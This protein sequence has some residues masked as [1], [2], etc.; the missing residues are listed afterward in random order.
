VEDPYAFD[1]L[2]Q[3]FYE[4]PIVP[5]PTIER[6]ET[7]QKSYE[8]DDM[9]VFKQLRLK[10]MNYWRG[11]SVKN[12][13]KIREAEIKALKKEA[14]E[15]GIELEETPVSQK[16]VTGEGP[17]EATLELTGGVKEHVSK[18]DIT[19]DAD[20][21]DYLPESDDIEARG[22]PI[23]VLVPQATTMKADKMVY[24]RAANIVKLYG[25][26]EVIKDGST[27]YGDFMQVNLNEETSYADNVKTN[28]DAVTLTSRTAVSDESR[29]I[30]EDGKITAEQ[31][32]ILKFKSSMIRG[33][34]NDAWIIDDDDR[35]FIRDDVGHDA[36][37]IKTNG[38]TVDARKKHTVISAKEAE[39]LFGDKKLFTLPAFKAFTNKAGNY[40]EANYPELGSIGMLG[41]YAGPGIVFG[42]P[43]GAVIKAMPILNYRNKIGVGGALK[44]KSATNTTD[45]AYGTAADVFIVR[46]KQKFDDNF[47]LQYGINSYMDDWFLGYRRPKYMVEA[48][49]DNSTVI[50]DTLA[51]GLNLRFRHRISGGFMKD[52][53]VNRH[54]EDIITSNKSTSRFRYMAE[55]AQSVYKYENRE[56]RELLDLSLVMQGSAAI[57]GTGDTQFI[58]RVG[59]NIHSQYKN[60]MQDIGYF[61]SAYQ[62]NTPMP[63]FDSYRYGHSAI[64][65][66]EAFRVNK[67]ITLAWISTINLS[68]D[69]P[70]R[71]M[72]QEN[73]FFVS[74]G[75]DDLKFTL[76][77]DVVRRNTYFTIA[78]AM[79]AKGSS[80]EFK[81][82]EIKNPDRLTQKSTK[83]T[84]FEDVPVM[85]KPKMQYAQVIDI[86]DP[87]KEQI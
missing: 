31:S 63:V 25:N 33:A 68:G 1:K 44:Y 24:S 36:V 73:G 15:A 56:Q 14:E 22:N 64:V 81:K 61:I 9:P 45:I 86:E 71:S 35:S 76:G 32:F 6:M 77:Y 67:Y 26:V 48:V 30:L 39:I 82:M 4:A 50:K 85:S 47:H 87:N 11:V 13:E 75:P 46:G 3:N 72:F 49:Y 19:L 20:I 62:D 54:D 57:Y 53:D 55:I 80:V 70:N 29:L 8:T 17:S 18:N 28:M 5:V 40:F 16:T 43:N 7:Q 74:L 78:L 69:A 23:L 66:K 83:I 52:S 2:Y 10:F 59:P 65:F 79:D 60:W 38:I 42:I 37:T 27:M 41:M 58:G 21:I 51:K 34:N 12:E 84:A